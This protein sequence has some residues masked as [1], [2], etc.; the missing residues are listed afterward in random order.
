MIIN[1]KLT[2]KDWHLFPN[3]SAYCKEQDVVVDINDMQFYSWLA[4]DVVLQPVLTPLSEMTLTD[5]SYFIGLIPEAFSMVCAE[6]VNERGIDALVQAR[7]VKR[8]GR[9]VSTFFYWGSYTPEQVRFLLEHNYDI[10]GWINKNIAVSNNDVENAMW[11]YLSKELKI[12]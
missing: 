3:S 4:S 7:T 6:A 2:L 12:A 8:A 5:A 1:N 11:R 9:K 10:F